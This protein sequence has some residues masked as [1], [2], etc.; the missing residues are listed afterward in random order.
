MTWRKKQT[1]TVLFLVLLRLASTCTSV[2]WWPLRWGGGSQALHIHLLLPVLMCK[3]GAVAPRWLPPVGAKGAT[4]KEERVFFSVLTFPAWMPRVAS[5]LTRCP[6]LL[7]VKWGNNAYL[8]RMLQELYKS[9]G[10]CFRDGKCWYSARG[11]DFS[12]F[13]VV[14]LVWVFGF[15]FFFFT[16]DSSP[17]CTSKEE[18]IVIPVAWKVEFITTTHFF[19]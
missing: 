4:A 15:G 12:C 13:W 18:S 7:S 17:E 11:I 14:V 3:R 10:K 5:R 1:I 9:F 6:V 2:Q 19:K 16:P 8:I